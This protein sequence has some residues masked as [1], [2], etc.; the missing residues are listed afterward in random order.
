MHSC[1]N[2]RDRG[3][4]DDGDGEGK[5]RR[6]CWNRAAIAQVRA[7]DDQCPMHI[8]SFVF[9][10]GSIGK[11]RQRFDSTPPRFIARAIYLLHRGFR[12]FAPSFSL[13]FVRQSCPKCEQGQVHDQG[14]AGKIS[15]W[16]NLSKAQRSSATQP[17][18]HLRPVHRVTPVV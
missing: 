18:I 6:P 15:R 11:W 16:S 14:R 5:W 8:P 12:Q 10:V 1:W 3:R 13:Q 7:A 17:V 9:V 2:G 4:G